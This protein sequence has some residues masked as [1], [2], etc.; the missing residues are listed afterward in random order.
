MLT[1]CTVPRNKIV[2]VSWQLFSTF[3]LRITQIWWRLDWW[4][5]LW[6]CGMPVRNAIVW[7]A[8]CV[9]ATCCC[10]HSQDMQQAKSGCVWRDC[11]HTCCHVVCCYLTHWSSS[12][13]H[14]FR[15]PGLRYILFE[16]RFDAVWCWNLIKMVFKKRMNIILLQWLNQEGDG[17]SI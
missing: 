13:W 9:H 17:W 15:T 6:V 4:S 5:T 2:C 7:H 16:V 10:C 1:L 14:C 11:W 3:K 8:F 12:V